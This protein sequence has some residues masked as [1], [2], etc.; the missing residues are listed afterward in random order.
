MR[1]HTT[2]HGEDTLRRNHTLE[3]FRGGLSTDENYLLSLI[4]T[5]LGIF[6]SEGQVSNSGSRRCRVTSGDRLGILQSL[7]DKGGVEQL[8]QRTSIDLGKS[9]FLG[10]NLFLG[11]VDSNVQ[12]SL[13]SSLSSTSLEHEEMS[14]LNCELKVL[15]I[16]V[17][18]LKLVSILYEVLI[19]VRH[20]FLELGDRI[21]CTDTSN[22]ILTLSILQ[23]LSGK[24]LLTSGRTTSESDTS[25]GSGSH[26][27]ESHLHDGNSSSPIS[28]DVIQTTE[29]D[30]TRVV[31]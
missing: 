12:S 5:S 18:V 20:D 7:F 15:H 17:V 24:L 8:I 11:E 29:E 2:T 3:I 4:V 13:S 14:I 30:S 26:V 1:S 6:R 25:S 9:F 10:A 19:D 16:L 22:D 27:T 23:E 28:R 31:P 21:R